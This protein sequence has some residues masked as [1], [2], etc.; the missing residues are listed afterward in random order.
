MVRITEAPPPSR[1]ALSSPVIGLLALVVFINYVD[2]GNLATAAP[3][4][5]DRLKLSSTQVGLLLSACFWSYTPS[6]ILA[7]WLA[8]RINAYRTLAL[9]VALWS[10][11]TIG[12]G[13]ATDFWTLI[14]LRLLLGLGE[15]AAFPCSSKLLAL[16]LPSRRLGGANGWVAV[17]GAAFWGLM[18]RRI[19]PVDWFAQQACPASVASA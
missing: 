6:Q 1:A 11:A 9:G 19:A 4:I 8:E 15:S 3:L 18:I 16:H 10:L 13:F 7:G 5:K 14:V 2:R 17:A 12:S